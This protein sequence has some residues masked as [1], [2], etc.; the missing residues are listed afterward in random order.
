MQSTDAIQYKTYN[1]ILKMLG[2]CECGQGSACRSWQ[3]AELAANCN[4]G[5]VQML[6]TY[7][8]LN[9]NLALS[10]IECYHVLYIYIE[11]NG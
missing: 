7:I 5:R 11:A 10:V 6:Y 3:D 8:G 1:I 2:I 4:Q 9:L